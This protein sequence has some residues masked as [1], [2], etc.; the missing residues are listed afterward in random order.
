MPAVVLGV[1]LSPTVVESLAHVFDFGTPA[2][3]VLALGMKAPAQTYQS[4]RLAA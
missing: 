3:A 1:S 4:W 2:M